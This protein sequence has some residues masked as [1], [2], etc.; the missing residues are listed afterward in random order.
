LARALGLGVLEVQ[1]LP[2]GSAPD[3]RKRVI[4][5]LC[6]MRR[7]IPVFHVE[8]NPGEVFEIPELPGHTGPV[9][10]VSGRE[11]GLHGPGLDRS[12]S[13]V[14]DPE[15]PALRL[16]CWQQAL[17]GREAIDLERIARA[18]AL[19][20]KHIRT[21][22]QMAIACAA[23]QGRDHIEFED[24]AKA[25]QTLERQRLDTLATRL[26]SGGSW[27]QVV[28]SQATL[29][30]LDDLPGGLNTGVRALLEGPSGTGKTLAARVLAG[31]L[32]LDI[33]RVDLSALVNKYIGETEKNLS[34]VLNRAEELNVVLLLDEGDAL[35]ARRTDVKSSN[36]RYAN[37]ETNYLLQRLE[38]YTG[39]ALITTNS[40]GNI[41]PAFRRRM[42][43]V[44]KFHLPDAEQ[45]WQLW[46]LHLPPRHDVQSAEA[47]QIALRHAFTGGQIRNAAI[48][49][50]LLALDR[51]A[52]RVDAG[53]VRAAIEREYRK[54]GGVFPEQKHATASPHHG[55]ASFLESIG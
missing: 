45:R 33:Y 49:A 28:V 52:E 16:R 46:Q 18:F 7:A 26:E 5:P 14:L 29:A 2:A 11:G 20:A 12:V 19:P 6:L 41:D 13:L 27:N 44:V 54:S 51:R 43:V 21:S 48:Y 36:D 24:V 25:T 10:V 17:D 31:E 22:A 35:M 1:N 32:G 23:T 40:P 34:R 53:D 50:S 8:L 55:I 30:E 3:D 47:E 9:C 39:I 4:G 42:D 15:T 37:L 38:T